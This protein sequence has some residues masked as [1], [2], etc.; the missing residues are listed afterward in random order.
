M[1]TCGTSGTNKAEFGEGL[2][3]LAVEGGL[4]DREGERERD[5]ERI[6]FEA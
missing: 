5:A 4:V 1:R 2:A 6:R 3:V